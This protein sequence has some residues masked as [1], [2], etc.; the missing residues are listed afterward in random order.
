MAWAPIAAAGVSGLGSLY[1]G[2]E[3]AQATEYAANLQ[4]QGAA[5]ALQFQKGAAAQDLA[6]A[7]AVQQANYQQYAA[8]RQALNALGATV[9]APQVAIPDYVP[10]P[11]ADSA[12]VSAANYLNNASN[13]L[14]YTR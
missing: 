9:G 7:N 10:L 4:S 14:G 3:Q 12:G 2:K 11:N 5:N 1:A 13:V 8:R 6:T